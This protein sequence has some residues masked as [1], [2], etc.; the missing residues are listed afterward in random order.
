MN[1]RFFL[2]T[3]MFAFSLMTT[4]AVDKRKFDF[5]VGV[6]G[7]F[8]AAKTAAE[9]SRSG[10]FYIFFPDGNYNIGALTGDANQRTTFSA[11]NVSL[12]GQSMSGVL[13]YNQS[14]SEGIGT[15]ATLDFQ[16]SA[17]YTYMQDL[18]FQNKAYNNPN[19]SANRFV[20]IRDQADRN[21]YKNVKMLS[22]QDTYYTPTGERRSYL[23][24]CEIHGTVDYICGGG[25][26]YFNQ[27]LLFCENRANNCITA[28]ATKSSWGYVFQNCVIDGYPVNNGLL[29]L[30]R[31]WNGT[32]RAVYI[33]TRMKVS[34]T[35]EGWG[36]PMNTV[37]TLF[38][39]FN[40]M[41][42]NGN[43]IDLSRR[44]SYYSCSKDGSTAYFNPRLSYEEA[45]K[46]TVANVV[47]GKDGW[48]PDLAT[49]QMPAP[50]V[51]TSGT[52]L[53]WDDMED[54][55]CYFIF[56]DGKYL[57]NVSEPYYTVYET[58][59][60]EATYTV[61]A[62]NEMGGLG[63]SS[64]PVN[65]CPVAEE[66]EEV[67]WN[68]YNVYYYGNGEVSSTNGNEFNNL[69]SCT[70]SGSEGFAWAITGRDDK[71]VLYGNDIRVGMKGGYYTTFKNS[72][73]AQNTFYLPENTTVNSIV[74]MGYT[75][76]SE[77]IGLLTEINGEQIEEPFITNTGR[78]G[79][80]NVPSYVKYDFKEDVCGSFTFTFS[81]KQ[82]CFVVLMKTSPCVCSSVSV[83]DV[84]ADPSDGDMN[85]YD[86][87][88][89]KVEQL[90]DGEIYIHQ[91]QA[92]KI[93]KN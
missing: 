56:K 21:I 91:G 13:I 36:D 27:C 41:D 64:N 35:A 80:A 25:D 81:N 6:D 40:S 62:A 63:A 48:R 78:T 42:G 87:S 32:P 57:A 66:E 86:L 90:R 16:K 65:V 55:L 47:G 28:P 22:T 52:K 70:E 85:Y 54:A 34:P 76:D 15:T 29:R 4:N 2:T 43:P 50:N 9:A 38:A 3:L 53:I 77:G 73:G 59:Y 14:S 5:V 79:Y 8:K 60:C 51:S 45:A 84:E 17:S 23:E 31:S 49:R 83:D 58:P 39:E 7:D 10:R 26:L 11:A 12:I 72:N 1:S 67:D 46:Y 89:R 61:R 68:E 30:G 18:T 82:I 33:N 88:G 75:N 20:V 37:P 69:W 19:A 93:I 74:F 24:N 71:N 44:R 92:V